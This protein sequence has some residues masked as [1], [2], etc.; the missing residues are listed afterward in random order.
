MS[1]LDPVAADGTAEGAGADNTDP[2]RTAR[3]LCKDGHGRNGGAGSESSQ[4]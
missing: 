1:R 4:G 3:A 2:K